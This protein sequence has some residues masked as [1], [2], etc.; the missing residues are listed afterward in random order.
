[1]RPAQGG[2]ICSAGHRPSGVEVRLGAAGGKG[3]VQHLLL[4]TVQGQPVLR[5]Q[6]RHQ[7]VAVALHAGRFGGGQ[8]VAPCGAGA[9]GLDEAAIAQMID[10]RAAAKKARNFAE[11]DRI[12]DELKAAGI[13]LDDSPQGTTWR[14]A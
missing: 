3:G 13:V 8:R 2:R 1:M 11:A 12:R 5:P 4:G 14:R 10:D 7:L 6:G 9:G